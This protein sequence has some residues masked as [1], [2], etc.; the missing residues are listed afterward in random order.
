M[1]AADAVRTAIADTAFPLEHHAEVLTN[2]ADQEVNA[3]R[4]LVI[5]IF[6]VMAVFLLFQAAFR[7]WRLA[8]VALLSLPAALLGGVIVVLFTGLSLG[9][10]LG[11]LAVVGVTV[12]HLL[13][14]VA[15]A[16][17]SEDADEQTDGA[18][19]AVD[20]AEGRLPA[21][22]GSAIAIAALTVPVIFLGP[23]P[24]LEIIHP[25]A[26]V[27]LGGLLTST[28]LTLFLLPAL[29]PRSAPHRKAVVTQA[30]REPETVR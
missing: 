30:E 15:E 12:R 19:I 27:L 17:T 23:R 5:S 26:L 8:G 13:L 20:A 14:F 2:T 21:V 22:L 11:L 6:A 18:A 1:A 10:A 9:A 24:G 16:R 25:L 28:L 29:Y 3:P 7:S 4:V